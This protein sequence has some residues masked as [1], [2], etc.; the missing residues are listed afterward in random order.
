MQLLGWIYIDSSH[1]YSRL[2]LVS[3]FGDAGTARVGM[4]VGNLLKAAV[5]SCWAILKEFLLFFSSAVAKALCLKCPTS[6]LAVLNAL[7][8]CLSP[9]PMHNCSQPTSSNRSSPHTLVMHQ[10]SHTARVNIKAAY[11]RLELL[12]SVG[13]NYLLYE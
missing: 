6:F 13:S 7:A 10:G 11:H 3:Y 2:L 4:A 8:S 12:C 5:P 9:S 1:R